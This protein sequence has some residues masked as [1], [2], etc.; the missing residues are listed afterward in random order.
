MSLRALPLRL[1][2]GA[3]VLGLGVAGSAVP[4]AAKV[5]SI[6]FGELVRTADF[7]GLVRVERVRGIPLLRA[8]RATAAV[9]EPWKGAA[10][11]RV[12]Y[13]AA[14][15]WI[16]DISGAATGELAVVFLDGGRLAHSGR[17]RMTAFTRD[18]R[19]LVEVWPEVRLPDGLRAEPGLGSFTSG[20]AID[21]LRDAVGREGGGSIHRHATAAVTP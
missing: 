4:L 19:R 10:T 16:C 6:T 9:L 14:P 5:A 20:V 2:T 7:I 12:T 15:D 18:G 17:G 8:P 11:R 3:L 1:V 13:V 21:D